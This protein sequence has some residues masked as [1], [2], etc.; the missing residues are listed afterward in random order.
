MATSAEADSCAMV[1]VVGSGRRPTT[2]RP[3]YEVEELVAPEV[4]GFG[5]QR[6]THRHELT[7]EQWARLELLDTALT[8]V[9][10]L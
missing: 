4:S 7:D 2:R 9:L 6:M 3:V 8:D 10:N 5:T 1:I